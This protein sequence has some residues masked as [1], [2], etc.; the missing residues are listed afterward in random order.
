TRIAGPCVVMAALWGSRTIYQFF[1]GVVMLGASIPSFW[2][3]L[4]LMQIF[5]VGLGWF[6]VAGYGNPGVPLSER[7][8]HLV[9]PSIVLGI[10]NSALILRFTRASMLDVLG[11]D[12][13]RTARAKGLSEARA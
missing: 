12:H 7:L 4:I 13:I 5:A 3:G 10:V 2:F 1:S 8:H 6:P 11:D 9:L